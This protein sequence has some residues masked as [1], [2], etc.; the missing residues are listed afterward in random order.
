MLEPTKTSPPRSR[1]K[2]MPV[3][4]PPK[5]TQRKRLNSESSLR[6]GAKS[7]QTTKVAWDESIKNQLSITNG[8]KPLEI[9]KL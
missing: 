1:S 7:G 2:S 6:H 5:V 9:H 8:V 3:P 4:D